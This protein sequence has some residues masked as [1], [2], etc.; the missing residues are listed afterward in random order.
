MFFHPVIIM[1][2]A[3]DIIVT[4]GIF[5]VIKEGVIMTDKDIYLIDVD[6][7]VEPDSPSKLD[8]SVGY[9]ID[10]RKIN[11]E[12]PNC[13]CKIE[14]VNTPRGPLPQFFIRIS[15]NGFPFDP[16]GMNIT[17]TT[18]SGKPTWSLRLVTELCF[19]NYLRFL[20]T[21]NKAY[22]VQA[23]RELRSNGI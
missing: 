22:F 4:T 10:G 18:R 9:T 19:N 13:L 2:L 16:W 14:M 7:E 15:A 5:L 21:R 20:K 17:Q 8:E 23:D 12:D 6:K 1:V 3:L 11:V